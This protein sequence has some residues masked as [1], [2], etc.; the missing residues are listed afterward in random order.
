[1]YPAIQVAELLTITRLLGLATY[2]ADQPSQQ[3]MNSLYSLL[4]SFG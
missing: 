3:V 2:E 4:S 1:M